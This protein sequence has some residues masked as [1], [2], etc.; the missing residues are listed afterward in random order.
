MANGPCQVLGKDAFTVG[1]ICALPIELTT[2]EGMLD[3]VYPA[4][5]QVQGD[6]NI[7][8]LGRIGQHNIVIAW[9]SAGSTGIAPAAKVAK[10]MLRSFPQIRFG[11][12]VGI[13]GGAPSVNA[14]IR[15]GDVVV[16]VPDGELGGVVKF[17][18]GKTVQSGTFEHTGVLNMPPA[19]VRN[20][21]NKLRA[22]HEAHKSLVAR[23]VSEMIQKAMQ[24][25]EGNAHFE[26]LYSYQGAQY[27]QL[28]DASYEHEDFESQ[29]HHSID[30]LVRI[31]MTI[32]VTIAGS[33]A[34]TWS[35]SLALS[36]IVSVMISL[37]VLRVYAK[38]Q[39]GVRST[40]LRDMKQPCPGCN[41][42]RLIPRQPR[43]TTDPIIHYGTIGSADQVMRHGITRDAMRKKHQILCFEM[44]AAGLMNDFPCL[45]IR[46]ICDYS[47]T[48]KHKL[49]QRYAAAT[50]AAY[51]KELLGVI[52]PTEVTKM[53]AAAEI[54]ETLRNEIAGVNAK[55]NPLIF[56][57]E[58]KRRR[59]ILSWLASST[60]EAE[61][62]DVFNKHQSGT[63]QG[64]LGS[65]KFLGWINEE[66]PT[67]LC[68]G[69][70][71]AGKTVLSSVVIDYLQREHGEESHIAYLYCT[72]GKRKDQ[73][74]YNL[75][76]TILR[77]FS[78]Q[79]TPIPK[80]VDLLYAFHTS[81]HSRPTYDEIA[82]TLLTV[83][84]GLSKSFLVVDALD[85]CSDETSQDLLKEVQMLQARTKLSFM[86]T[87]RKSLQQEFG[88]A[89]VLE[90]RAQ[91]TDIERYLDS[92]LGKLSSCV[93]KDDRLRQ[94]I[95]AQIIQSSDGMFL[96]ATLHFESLKDKK[97]KN[98]FRDALKNLPRG[99]HALHMA[100]DSAM[101]R[102]N[103]QRNNDRR[104][105]QRVLSW[106]V[107]AVRP[108]RPEE[109]RHALAVIEGN[110]QL[111]DDN[112]PVLDEVISLCAGLVLVNQDS[113]TIQLVHFTTYEYFSNYD[114]NW[115]QA[116]RDLVATTC[117]TYL[118]FDVFKSGFCRSR[119]D[120]NARMIANPL[121]EY[122]TSNWGYHVH[123]ST[124]QETNLITEFL[125]QEGNT[126][127]CAQVLMIKRKQ[128]H[129]FYGWPQRV[130]G[131]HL[132][133]YFGLDKA[134]QILL[135][136]HHIKNLLDSNEQTPLCWAARGGQEATTKL[137]LH[138]GADPNLATQSTDE[139][140]SSY[141]GP[142]TPIGWAVRIGSEIIVDLLLY[143]GANPEP[144]FEG[145]YSP[146]WTAVQSGNAEIARLLLEHQANPN[147]GRHSPSPLWWATHVTDLVTVKLLLKHGANPDLCHP[148]GSSPL[149][150]AART[151]NAEMVILLLSYHADPNLCHY[152]GSS[153]L[154]WAAREDNVEIVKVLLGCKANPD[155]HRK[156][157]HTPLF[158]A[159]RNG[160]SEI[161]QLLNEH[162]AI[163]F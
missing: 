100:Y 42:L 46:G 98:E 163:S 51:A 68:P 55:L 28:Y 124:L 85:E 94:D 78:E 61:Q 143:H 127:A 67:L 113:N 157:R 145:G 144:R 63:C 37:F 95:K 102:I 130:S 161:I 75:L 44:E 147:L 39:Q 138:H 133:A 109:L 81:R 13:G 52:P 141:V 34:I 56:G 33:I 119:S 140:R 40:E 3:D 29:S 117:T 2:S 74:A 45:V 9:L 158:W 153:P 123:S 16:G 112:I 92:R 20:G 1:W 59:D 125:E 89:L 104:W 18:R 90:I 91:G 129:G 155:L 162:N 83:C 103:Q 93:T 108:L 4:L 159:Q 50:A 152:D 82:A 146:L 57:H 23:Y 121:Y 115:R 160:N 151:P 64:F 35:G 96:L 25:E 21:V 48:H 6:E 22:K 148:D 5:E 118:R 131:T 116:A 36:V 99:L 107:Q 19:Q 58:L 72:Y 135:R 137:L 38:R 70:P 54:S 106:V 142:P 10:D 134:L 128:S 43:A 8:T 77:Q 66:S 132:A 11:L 79:S 60:H 114:I 110:Y 105:A 62:A 111:E 122:A 139:L 26:D 7:Y 53:K 47:D 27:D 73:T 120:F 76:R 97:T 136:R 156:D 86:V 150:W 17:D 154:W 71:G 32:C 49:W 24:S 80:S 15:L 30:N 149:W 69:I 41:Q 126:S 88:N 101:E 84:R 87:S 12:M 31:F 65:S 14:D